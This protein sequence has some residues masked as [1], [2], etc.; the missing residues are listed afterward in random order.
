L[1]TR[2]P[3]ERLLILLI[4]PRRRESITGTIRFTGLK[5]KW[6]VFGAGVGKKFSLSKFAQDFS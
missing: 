5:W 3:E 6:L 1:A 2:E 4:S